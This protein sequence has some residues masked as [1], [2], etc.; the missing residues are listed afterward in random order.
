PQYTIQTAGDDRLAV[1]AGGSR[2][3]VFAGAAEIALTVPVGRVD[4]PHLGIAAAGD[5]RV[6]S[7]KADAGHFL[8]ELILHSTNLVSGPCIPNLEHHIRATGYEHAAVGPPG[9]AEHMVR[10]AFERAHRLAV[11]RVPKLYEAVCGAA[12]NLF[13]VWRKREA[14]DRVAMRLFD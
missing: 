7:H 4:Q 10:V 6:V 11:G 3:H 13:A 5:Y 8:R 2:V 12:H 14:I 1:A 9:D